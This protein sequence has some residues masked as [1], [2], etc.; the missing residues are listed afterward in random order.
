V[1]Q[2][3]GKEC[4]S[5][6]CRAYVLYKVLRSFLAEH[7]SNDLKQRR[8]YKRFVPIIRS[9]LEATAKLAAKNDS[10]SAQVVSLIWSQLVPCLSQMLTPIP[11]SK[12][13][14]KIARVPEIVT[15]VSIAHVNVPET[16]S[17]ELCGILSFG[18]SQA[19]EASKQHSVNAEANPESEF[20]RKSKRHRDD[21]LKLFSLCF[22]GCCALWPEEPSISSMAEMILNGAMNSSSDS[23]HKLYIETSLLVC[24]AF[25]E[26]DRMERPIMAIFPLLCRLILSADSAKNNHTKLRDAAGLV[27]TEKANFVAL[28]QVAETRYQDAEKRAE[29]AERQV[30][31][32]QAVVTELQE[33][34][35]DLQQK[36]AT[37]LESRRGLW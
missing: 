7:Q 12:G 35:T 2:E 17:E 16:F 19:L 9:G 6:E 31:E 15:I 33:E 24:Q 20:G 22:S 23:L 5:D 25:L 28:W 37:A 36:L 27:L 13:L 14:L 3:I 29:S 30:T 11:L 32:L 4:V 26:N 18:A 34:K 1:A 10:A 8:H 21:L